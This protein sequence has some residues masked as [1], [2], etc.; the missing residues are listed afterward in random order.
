VSKP[1]GELVVM[2]R[3]MV[4]DLVTFAVLYI[5]AVLGFGITLHG[6][7]YGSIA[8]TTS[9]RTFLSIFAFTLNTFSYDI[10]YTNNRY[11]DKLGLVLLVMLLIITSILLINLLI[12]RMTN[13]HQ[14]II[15]QAFRVWSFE[16]AKTVKQMMLS[17]ERHA[18]SMLP[19]P[20]NY[21]TMLVAPV[22]YYYL[23]YT[24]PVTNSFGSSMRLSVAGTLS[25][26]VLVYLGFP[27]RMMRACMKILQRFPFYFVPFIL[28]VYILY[29]IF[30]MVPMLPFKWWID[31]VSDNGTLMYAVQNEEFI[32]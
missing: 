4:Q 24:P 30:I 14:Y 29:D 7:F 11:V 26:V 32:E 17:N 15:Q 28:S 8:F 12:A 19:A 21:L 20:L 16:K 22:H 10:F 3:R 18:C 9:G 1:L 23:Y 6:I 2:I 31:Y 27:I 5:T 25:N 13:S